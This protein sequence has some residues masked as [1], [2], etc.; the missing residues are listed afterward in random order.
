M[1]HALQRVKK[2]TNRQKQE[3]HGLPPQ[4]AFPLGERWQKSLI[5]DG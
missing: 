1:Q 3:Y 5:F 4:K 2:A